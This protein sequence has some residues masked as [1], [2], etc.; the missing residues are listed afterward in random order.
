MGFPG[1][2]IT[3]IFGVVQAKGTLLARYQSFKGLIDKLLKDLP[4]AQSVTLANPRLNHA[5]F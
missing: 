3:T 4:L 5:L 1:S 2:A